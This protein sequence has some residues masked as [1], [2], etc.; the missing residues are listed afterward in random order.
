MF[1]ERHICTPVKSVIAGSNVLIDFQRRVTD[2]K[3]GM[4][5]REAKSGDGK[6]HLSATVYTANYVHGGTLLVAR[7]D[8]CRFRAKKQAKSVKSLF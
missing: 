8:G 3:V 6:K 4:K 5:I 7:V 1:V 2:K